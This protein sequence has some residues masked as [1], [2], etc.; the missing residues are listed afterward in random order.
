MED[1]SHIR[2]SPFSQSQVIEGDVAWGTKWEQSMIGRKTQTWGSLSPY[3][4]QRPRCAGVPHLQASPPLPLSNSFP[5]RPLSSITDCC[6]CHPF[7]HQNMTM[8]IQ[9]PILQYLR[10]HK[11]QH[12]NLCPMHE[13]PETKAEISACVQRRR[14]QHW[15]FPGGIAIGA[16]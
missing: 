11:L 16:R 15:H 13:K 4:R 8:R 2:A 10:R 12:A 1:D 7:L 6:Y 5:G 9:I 14:F 3:L